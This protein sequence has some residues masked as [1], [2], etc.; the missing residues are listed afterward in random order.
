M[1]ITFYHMPQ[2]F[3]PFVIILEKL[4]PDVTNSATYKCLYSKLELQKE[5]IKLE[6][7]PFQNEKNSL[8]KSGQFSI[9]LASSFFSLENHGSVKQKSPL[10]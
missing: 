6:P 1:A 8:E 2:I 4:L 10:S 7:S 5:N 9:E 3:P